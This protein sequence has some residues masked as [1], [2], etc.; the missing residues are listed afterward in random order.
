M[1]D[2]NGNGA[3]AE[4]LVLGNP[5]EEESDAMEQTIFGGRV[6]EVCDAQIANNEYVPVKLD[7][8]VLGTL[9]SEQV[10][11]SDYRQYHP[12]M[13]VGYYKVQQDGFDLVNCP[14]CCRFFK[15]D[16]FDLYFIEHGSCPFCKSKDLSF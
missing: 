1:W 7:E 5:D 2:I 3:P 10:F 9:E 6:Q 12:Q 4:H 8:Y 11:W 14:R 16:E 15:A 13:K